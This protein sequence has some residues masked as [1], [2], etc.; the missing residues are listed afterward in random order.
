MVEGEDYEGASRAFIEIA[1]IVDSEV[2]YMRCAGALRDAGEL[3][4]AVLYCDKA[5][6]KNPNLHSAYAVKGG[7][8]AGTGDLDSALELLLTA[9]F[10]CKHD[11]LV[12]YNI[13]VAYMQLKNIGKAVEYFEKAIAED[14][15]SSSAH[16]NLGGCLY[17]QG[18]FN[19]ALK[20][21]EMA[22][23]LEPG[24]PQAL[25]Q[26]GEIKRF[27]GE[28]DEAVRYFERCLLTIPDNYVARLGLAL[29]LI[30]KGEVSGFSLFVR[31]CIEEY[32][33]EL[34]KTIGVVDVGWDRSNC[35]SIKRESNSVY[36]VGFYDLEVRVCI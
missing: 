28:V 3:E 32:D 4:A 11:A 9:A 27:Y 20:H 18:A 36:I 24:L 1:G 8:I 10:H 23:L 14:S 34:E 2:V 29:C 26:K 6:E 35:I 15:R 13:G 5:I 21:T 19:G 12:L 33:I 17:K 22:L 31:F 25:S 30:E 16:L 7:V